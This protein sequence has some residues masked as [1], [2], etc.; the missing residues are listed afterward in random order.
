M[1]RIQFLHPDDACARLGLVPRPGE[2]KYAKY[3]RRRHLKGLK[4][5]TGKFKG[6]RYNA[7]EVDQLAKQT[8]HSA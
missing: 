4:R 1:P 6:Y 8:I 2:G 5:Y 3:D 7:A